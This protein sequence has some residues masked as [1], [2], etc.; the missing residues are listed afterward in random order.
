MT[1]LKSI[2]LGKL[3]L[4]ADTPGEGPENDVQPPPPVQASHTTELTEDGG[5]D[6]TLECRAQDIR[7]IDNSNS[8]SDLF[9]LVEGRKKVKRARPAWGCYHP[10]EESLEDQSGVIVDSHQTQRNPR[11]EKYRHRD[12][13]RGARP[14]QYHIR[15]DLANDIADIVHGHSGRELSALES[16]IFVQPTE[17]GDTDRLP[18]HKVEKV[19]QPQHRLSC[20]N[21]RDTRRRDGMIGNAS[22]SG[23]TH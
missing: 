12:G 20:V 2:E 7:A 14:R 10:K 11:R 17:N 22:L 9:P 8:R 4:T 19:E 13:P 21:L 16:E 15:R 18:L 1:Q 23:G 5:S 6:E 3:R